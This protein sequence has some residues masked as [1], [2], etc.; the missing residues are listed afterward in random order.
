MCLRGCAAEGDG[1]LLL[2]RADVVVVVVRLVSKVAQ[3]TVRKWGEDGGVRKSNGMRGVGK[4]KEVE[5]GLSG[6][7][8]LLGTE[9]AG[10]EVAAVPRGFVPRR[11]S[12]L[13]MFQVGKG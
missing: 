7:W 1:H 11:R 6:E 5:V 10:A 12:G 4:L 13:W 3:V 9:S 2:D 8:G